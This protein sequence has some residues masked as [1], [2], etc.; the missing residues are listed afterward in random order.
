MRT[1]LRSRCHRRM[2]GSMRTA[3]CLALVAGTLTA[4]AQAQTGDH[5]IVPG[6]R[7]GPISVGMTL[8][9]ALRAAGSPPVRSLFSNT[10]P[11]SGQIDFASG[12]GIAVR[13]PEQRVITI[14]AQHPSKFRTRGGVAPGMSEVEI[15]TRLGPPA[16]RIGDVPPTVWLIYPGLTFT[17]PKG[18]AFTSICTPE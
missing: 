5:L 6:E 17:A 14:C 16:K 13:G 1:T 3:L 2:V 7:I 4:A 8:N 10:D 18:G 9:Q 12:L 11:T 15:R